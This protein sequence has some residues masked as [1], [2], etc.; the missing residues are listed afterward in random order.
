MLLDGDLIQ[1]DPE[2]ANRWALARPRTALPPAM[3]RLG[4]DWWR[5]G[6]ERGD[7]D[8]QAMLGAAHHLGIGAALDRVGAVAWLQRGQ[9]G[10]SAL[11]APFLGAARA[12]LSPDEM[13]G[14]ERLAKKAPPGVAP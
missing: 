14:P 8:A 1:T 5:R 11:A 9:A 12:A 2:G 7:A 3:S 10:G 13:A 4:A 6:G